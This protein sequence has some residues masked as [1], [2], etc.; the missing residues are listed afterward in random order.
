MAWARADEVRLTI[1]CWEENADVV[2]SDVNVSLAVSIRAVGL[3]D[4]VDGDGSVRRSFPR[5]GRA[6]IMSFASKFGCI[7]FSTTSARFSNI[8]T[9]L[10]F[11]ATQYKI[12]RETLLSIC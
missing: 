1:S 8:N 6:D 11:E 9:A 12:R 2:G 3:V 7:V 4:D 5:S 10:V